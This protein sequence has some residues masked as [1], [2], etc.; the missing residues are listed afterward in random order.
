MFLFQ[1]S[2]EHRSEL[3]L[4]QKNDQFEP[5]LWKLSLNFLLCP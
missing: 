2:E 5:T 1:I 3:T 4:C